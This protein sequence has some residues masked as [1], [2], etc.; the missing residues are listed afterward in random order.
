M[1]YEHIFSD[2]FKGYAK[3]LCF[4]LKLKPGKYFLRC[5]IEKLRV[6][7]RSMINIVSSCPVKL[8]D[9]KMDATDH[10]HFLNETVSSKARA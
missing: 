7:Y 3:D 1:L 4:H 2:Y 10:K 6:E 5:K 9:A 8:I